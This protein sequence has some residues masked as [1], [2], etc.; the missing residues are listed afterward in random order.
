MSRSNFGFDERDLAA[1]SSKQ[2]EYVSQIELDVL[3]NNVAIQQVW[4]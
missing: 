4:W 2:V 3:T 1:K